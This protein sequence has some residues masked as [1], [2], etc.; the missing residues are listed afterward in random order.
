MGKWHGRIA[1]KREDAAAPR[2]SSGPT[3]EKIEPRNCPLLPANPS[4][5]F[6]KGMAGP[7][8][9]DEWEIIEGPFDLVWNMS[10]PFAATDAN[11]APPANMDDGLIHM[12]VAKHPKNERGTRVSKKSMT[13]ILLGLDSGSI[14]DHKY[15]DLVATKAFV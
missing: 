4:D 6:E 7:N 2:G 1:Y 5:V 11:V 8:N 3:P 14:V 10:V 9:D 15:V 12:L 13:Q